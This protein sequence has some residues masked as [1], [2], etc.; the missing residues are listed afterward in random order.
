MSLDDVSGV[1]YE[2][3]GLHTE[4]LRAFEIALDEDPK[5]VPSLISMAVVLKKVNGPSLSVVRSFLTEA[6]RLDRMNLSAW[7]NLGM[8]YKDKGIT[9]ALEA[10]ECFE[11]ATLL[12]ET[13]PIEPFR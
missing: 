10:A 12:E 9:M 3:K 7:Y 5:H 6:L 11:A 2:A 8:L 1:I 4:A 13:A